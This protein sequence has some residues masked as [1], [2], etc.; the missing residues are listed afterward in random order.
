MSEGFLGRWAR[1]KQGAREGRPLDEP[2]AQAASPAT[3]T[4]V[5][6]APP[7]PGVPQ[8][9]ETVPDAPAEAAPPPTLD[10]TLQLTP[11]S[12]FTPFVARGVAPE[13]K[14]A[15]MKKLFSDP[16]F[17][18]MDRLDIYIDDYSIPDPLP[19]SMLRKMASAQFLNLFD[20]DQKNTVAVAAS[21]PAA[22]DPAESAAALPDP[23]TDASPN[24]QD[25][26][27]DP[28]LR[29]QQDHAAGAPG[30]GRGPQ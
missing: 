22:A 7:R 19:A 4:V 29:L 1:R 24:P 5:P 27:A 8:A 17:N 28:D 25:D 14:N 11:Q 13:V 12:D 18:V 30:S 21:A 10:D 23:A 2:P 15:A 3:A 16:H 26:H 6:A 20:D 9:V